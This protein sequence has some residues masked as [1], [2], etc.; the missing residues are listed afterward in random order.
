MSKQGETKIEAKGNVIK[1]TDTLT[2]SDISIPLIRGLLRRPVTGEADE[3]WLLRWP[4]A[5]LLIPWPEG[6]TP[7]EAILHWA[8][9]VLDIPSSLPST[10]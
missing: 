2:Y 6:M 10:Q 5:D 7:K 4:E 3:V 9:K 8:A 1:P